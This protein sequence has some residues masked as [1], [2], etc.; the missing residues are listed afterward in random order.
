MHHLAES[1]GAHE[2]ILNR[3]GGAANFGQRIQRERS[4]MAALA[5]KVHPKRVAGEAE[6][7][8]IEG[9][10]LRI[11]AMKLLESLFADGRGQVIGKRGILN[12]IGHIVIEAGYL[13][14]IPVSK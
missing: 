5:A 6:H 14:L 8:C 1:L 13:I 9:A 10:T 3:T 4:R 11:E 12:P 2:L 7:P